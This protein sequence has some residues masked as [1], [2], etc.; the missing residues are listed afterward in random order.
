[1]VG[2]VASTGGKVCYGEIVSFTCFQSTISW[3]Q[4]KLTLAAQ[5]WFLLEVCPICDKLIYF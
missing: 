1:M 5:C 3:G 4:D 2:R